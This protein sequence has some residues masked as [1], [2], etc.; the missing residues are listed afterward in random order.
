MSRRIHA[1]SKARELLPH[2]VPR[3]IEEEDTYMSNEEEDTYL[4]QG[5]EASPAPGLA[6]PLTPPHPT[7]R[8]RERE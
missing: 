3:D 4:R 5:R 8:E 6:W 7:E 1:R 2:P